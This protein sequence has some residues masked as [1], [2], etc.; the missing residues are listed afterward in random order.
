MLAVLWVRGAVER[1]ELQWPRDRPGALWAL[2]VR[3]LRA[4]KD[5]AEVGFIDVNNLVDIVREA[6]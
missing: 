2:A 3:V 1:W 4:A 5:S 6:E